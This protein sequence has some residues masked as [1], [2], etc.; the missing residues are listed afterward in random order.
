[1]GDEAPPEDPRERHK[2]LM[3]L[4]QEAYQKLCDTVYKAKGYTPDGVP[5]RKTLERFDLLDVQATG[6]LSR[7]GVE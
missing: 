5:L 2:L 3:D 6:L 1:M 7:F 4:R